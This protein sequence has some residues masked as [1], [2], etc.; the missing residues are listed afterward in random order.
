MK[1]IEQK[2]TEHNNEGSVFCQQT[3]DMIIIT[4]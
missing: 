3:T 1:Q 4:L 2:L